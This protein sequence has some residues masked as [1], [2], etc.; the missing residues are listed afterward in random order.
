MRRTSSPAS[1]RR[2]ASPSIWRA[3]PAPM[4][5]PP[6]PGLSPP[7]PA[8]CRGRRGRPPAGRIESSGNVAVPSRSVSAQPLTS[9]DSGRGFPISTNSSS[10]AAFAY[11]RTRRASGKGASEKGAEA[12]RGRGRSGSASLSAQRGED[13]K[14]SA[15]NKTARARPRARTIRWTF[16]A[17]HKGAAYRHAT[18]KRTASAEAFHEIPQRLLRILR[19]HHARRE[20]DA[21]CSELQGSRDIFAGLNAGAAEDTDV[22]VRGANAIDGLRDYLRLRGRH[23]DVPS[24]QLRW[25]DRD[26]FRRELREGLCLDGVVG[27]CD[28]LEAETSAARD[29]V[30]HLLPRDLALAVIDQRPGSACLEERLGRRPSGRGA[31]FDR[32]DVLAED[33]DVHELRDVGEIRHRRGEDDRRTRV[34]FDGREPL[35]EFPSLLP[36]DFRIG[37]EV[38]DDGRG[39]HRGAD[40]RP[41]EIALALRVSV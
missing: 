13:A 34:V 25:L 15:A 12:G 17:A 35:G 27:A 23:A 20:Q 39:A 41:A 40:G 28:H 21:H 31:W 38:H 4:E 7:D 29:G 32:V 30:G 9:I 18:S 37:L 19:L 26:V 1:A 10:R 6:A 8:A 3:S 2:S 16:P 14:T 24:D 36:E 33:R 22:R 5:K 11:T